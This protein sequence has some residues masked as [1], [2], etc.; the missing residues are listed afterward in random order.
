MQ[1]IFKKISRI[2]VCLPHN[3][4]VYEVNHFPTCYVKTTVTRKFKVVIYLNFEGVRSKETTLW[5]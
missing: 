3:I 4:A 5:D 1:D 2:W